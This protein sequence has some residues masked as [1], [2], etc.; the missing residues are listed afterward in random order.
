MR[1][2]DDQAREK[3]ALRHLLAAE[4]VSLAT[5][6]CDA[7][8]AN[9]GFV[10][11]G[12]AFGVVIEGLECTAFDAKPEVLREQAEKVHARSEHVAK[13]RGVPEG[14]VT[15][16]YGAWCVR[17]REALA[18]AFSNI[19]KAALAVEDNGVDIEEV[20]VALIRVLAGLGDP[21][22]DAQAL[23]AQAAKACELAQ[24]L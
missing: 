17:G 10:P 12:H 3:E 13:H 23:A 1:H 15:D 16:P 14:P 22:S 7:M 8:D 2:D 24:Q 5:T 21:N 6:M 20:N 18:E 9:P 11:C 19:Q 4:L